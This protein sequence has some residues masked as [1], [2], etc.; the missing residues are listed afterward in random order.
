MNRKCKGSIKEGSGR[1][2]IPTK[3]MDE[4]DKWNS[5]CYA[6]RE[7]ANLAI[8]VGARQVSTNHLVP[9]DKTKPIK[10]L[11][12]TTWNDHIRSPVVWFAG[13]DTVWHYPINPWQ[14][15]DA[16]QRGD[17]SSA[18]DLR[19]PVVYS[20]AHAEDE[21]SRESDTYW[22]FDGHL[23]ADKPRLSI[24]NI[25]GIQTSEKS[26]REDDDPPIGVLI[27]Y[28]CEKDSILCGS[29]FEN[30]S[31]GRILLIRLTEKEDMTTNE[32][33]EY[34]CGI[35]ER[36]KHL[37]IFLW[38]SIPCTGGSPVQRR[39]KHHARHRER[40]EA[41]DRLFTKLH[42]NL[43]ILAKKVHEE[44]VNGEIV[45]EWPSTNDWWGRKEIQ[46]MMTYFNMKMV[47]FSGCRVGATSKSGRLTKKPWRLITTSGD[48]IFEFSDLIC[49]RAFR[50]SLTG[51]NKEMHDNHEHI[52]GGKM[53]RESA[54]YPLVMAHK[55]HAVFNRHFETRNTGD[56]MGE[57]AAPAVE[58]R[59][60]SAFDVDDMWIVDTGSGRDLVK[61]S[62]GSRFSSF[63]VA[64]LMV[65]LNTGGGRVDSSEALSCS[66]NLDDYMMR[67]H[68]YLL[69]NTPSVISIGVRVNQQG[70]AFVWFPGYHPGIITANGLVIAL[71]T[72]NNMPYIS[73]RVIH[74]AIRDPEKSSRKV[75]ARVRD[76]ELELYGMIAI[77]ELATSTLS[78]KTQWRRA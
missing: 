50:D 64:A 42:R 6:I 75:G 30:T 76:G 34:A 70:F 47:D 74:D 28:C 58:T 17:K 12:G 65:S 43:M 57:A 3:E 20:Q 38:C 8:E 63:I 66:M 37:P 33:I 69:T 19:R 15:I 55:A 62:K 23:T 61:M 1:P 73:A 56:H 5:I 35:V 40:M 7:A 16:E 26:N 29:Q 78:A 11:A 53:T 31:A 45:F 18:R 51:K 71:I 77:G 32:G 22:H 68:A 46:Q 41:H 60:L 25:E 24:P 27:E 14:I 39:N 13:T 44:T 10:E 59:T 21:F 67:I 4:L 2:T 54:K 9:S 48:M 36:W 49:N 72:R 52:E